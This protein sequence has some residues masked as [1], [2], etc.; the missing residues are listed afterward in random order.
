M[1]G[2]SGDDGGGSSVGSCGDG[3]SG[4]GRGVMKAVVVVTA[5][6]G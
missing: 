6:V 1:G 5:T 4:S 3:C 2:G